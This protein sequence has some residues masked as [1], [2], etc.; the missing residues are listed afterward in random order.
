MS[1]RLYWV[2]VIDN[3]IFL[4]DSTDEV[5]AVR[6]AG[7][8][9][10]T[11]ASATSSARESKAPP[12]KKPRVEGVYVMK[13]TA[14]SGHA[15]PHSASSVASDD[16]DFEYIPDTFSSKSSNRRQQQQS[17]SAVTD[18]IDTVDL[19]QS[20]RN[21]RSFADTLSFSELQAQ[22][23][24]LER[25][26]AVAARKNVKKSSQRKAKAKAPAPA[27]PPSFWKPV[28]PIPAPKS[29]STFFSRPTQSSPAKP[30]IPKPVKPSVPQVPTKSIP[31]YYDSDTDSNFEPTPA[32]KPAS[33]VKPV[34]T[35][36]KPGGPSQTQEHLFAH[37]QEK[38]TAVT[39]ETIDIYSDDDDEF[40]LLSATYEE[41][42]Q[43]LRKTSGQNYG[44]ATSA[45]A[46]PKRKRPKTVAKKSDE[47]KSSSSSKSH[48]APYKQAEPNV[49]VSDILPFRRDISNTVIHNTSW[50]QCYFDVAPV[51]LLPSS[52][53]EAR[54]C[55]ISKIYPPLTTYGKKLL[56][57]ISL[58]AQGFGYYWERE[59]E[60]LNVAF[61]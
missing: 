39:S 5:V 49:I 59:F 4:D 45:P 52:T 19:D 15:N 20:R 11:A 47:Q 12:N 25:L 31:T 46:K 21:R 16:S 29:A 56:H 14:S 40:G 9:S 22:Q 1:S 34:V 36:V 8:A 48:H 26:Q 6:T 10:V 28:I 17:S 30:I 50:R 37:A 60:S 38:S 13:K 33:R 35:P 7:R 18:K 32:K 43:V 24:A 55:L 54:A 51:N 58:A 27:A 61:P 44:G 57:C 2:L 41:S 23:R 42:S 53:G 3:V